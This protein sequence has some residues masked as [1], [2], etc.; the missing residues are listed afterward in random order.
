MDDFNINNNNTQNG[1]G[2]MDGFDSAEN[3]SSGNGYTVTP[4][5]GFYTKPKEEIIQDEVFES[6]T[7]SEPQPQ[8]AYTQP[9][10]S[11][12]QPNHS[13][14]YSTSQPNYYNQTPP[15]GYK[16]PKVKKPREKKTYGAG[17]I[18]LAVILAIIMGAI[19]GAA[20]VF[21]TQDEQ[22]VTIEQPG[23][24]GNNVNI[25][26]DETAESVVEAVATKVTPSVVGIRTTT[27]VMSFF[28][29]TSEASGEGSGVIYSSDGYIIT[30][31]HVI[32]DAI[33]NKSASKLEVFLDNASSE[34]FPA[35]VVGYNIS[36]DLAVI[37]INA[38]GLTPVEITDS[39][40]LKVGQYVITIGNPGGL[41]FMDS[42]TYGVVSGLNRV[43]SSDLGVELIQT[44]AAINPGNSGGAL[45]NTKGQLVGINSSKI[46][47]EE[48]EGMG[49]AIPSNTVVEICKRI[50]ERE[51]S[52]EPYVGISISEKYTKDVLKYY[53]FPSGAVV[54]SVAEG[55][56]A[57]KAGINRGDIIT[58]FDGTAI[59]EYTVL[60]DLMSD[61]TP[62]DTVTVK[63]YRSG[64]YYSTNIPIG[65]NNAVD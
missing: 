27:S 22:T 3:I 64:R 61:A 58:E 41:E 60:E 34:S 31:Y 37:K 32:A 13:P 62:G 54:L 51:N 16:P 39:D 23:V 59:T 36:S 48:Y 25:N 14:H 5:G 63:L 21:L 15:Y 30:N 28:G 24:S 40:K 8:P 49:F 52:P 44:D 43:V 10:T 65:Y 26:I 2:N 33:T 18:A 47:S 11:Y 7:E 19:S 9:Q 50:I 29:G 17:I 57:A 56:P 38:K 4:E 12:T 20:V 35:T 53:G 1:E 42:V 45:V 46:V 6:K 55:S